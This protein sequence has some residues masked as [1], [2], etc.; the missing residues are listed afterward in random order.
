MPRAYH[1][2][3]PGGGWLYRTDV[4][5][6]VR[7]VAGLHLGVGGYYEQKQLSFEGTGDVL[8]LMQPPDPPKLKV[9]S[10]KDEFGGFLLTLGYAYY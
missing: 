3:G 6:Y 5:L 2:Y 7:L 8:L 9:T 4:S 10:A 1:V